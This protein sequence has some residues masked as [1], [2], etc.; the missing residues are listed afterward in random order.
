MQKLAIL[1]WLLLGAILG[2]AVAV[3][4]WQ[5]GRIDP[6][7]DSPEMLLII[8]GCTVLTTVYGARRHPHLL[9]RLIAY[10]LFLTGL[11][12]LM[13]PQTSGMGQAFRRR[14]DVIAVTLLYPGLIVTLLL[15]GIL[16]VS[17]VKLRPKDETTNFDDAAPAT[18]DNESKS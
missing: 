18:E 10:P 4:L 6:D 9:P 7:G 8:A 17:F 3:H 2:W 11:A 5:A 16:A 14:Q 13:R 1:A 15:G 12:W